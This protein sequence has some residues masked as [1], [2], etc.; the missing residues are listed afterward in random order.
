MNLWQTLTLLFIFVTLF[1]QDVL[2]KKEKTVAKSSKKPVK[3]APAP[4]PKS[5]KKKT[6]KKQYE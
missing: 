3:K 5:S 4:T 1:V 6:S 2:G